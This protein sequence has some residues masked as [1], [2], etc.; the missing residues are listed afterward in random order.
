MFSHRR[1]EISSPCIYSFDFFKTPWGICEE[2]RR[3]IIH[4]VTRSFC[5]KLGTRTFIEIIRSLILT[6][7]SLKAFILI[8]FWCKS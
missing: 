2:E 8:I 3:Q 7:K 5:K 6:Q 4:D 1:V